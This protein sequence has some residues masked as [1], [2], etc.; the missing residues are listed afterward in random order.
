MHL[1]YSYLNIWIL[2]SFKQIYPTGQP[3]VYMPWKTNSE[4]TTIMANPE[5]RGWAAS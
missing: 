4:E 1:S 3:Y 5:G 2:T